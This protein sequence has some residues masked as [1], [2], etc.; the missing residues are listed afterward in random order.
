MAVGAI[1]GAGIGAAGG[2]VVGDPVNPTLEKEPG[3]PEKE[4]RP[5][6]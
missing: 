6:E 3:K 1:V 2:K 4:E 5:A